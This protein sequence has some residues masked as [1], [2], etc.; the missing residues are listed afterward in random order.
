M[1]APKKTRSRR[2]AASA[3]PTHSVQ[4]ARNGLIIGIPTDARGVIHR[5]ATKGDNELVFVAPTATSQRSS[6]KSDEKAMPLVTDGSN[7]KPNDLA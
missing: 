6:R 4:S 3:R 7:E 5:F 2:G 1:A